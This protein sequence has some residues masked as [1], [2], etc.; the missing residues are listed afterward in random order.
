MHQVLLQG[1][2]R[3][4]EVGVGVVCGI[5]HVGAVLGQVDAHVIHAGPAVAV[6]HRTVETTQG[7]VVLGVDILH[8]SL[9]RQPLGQLGTSC[10]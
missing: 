8:A 10:Q 1:E 2:Q 7:L 4:Q 3:V 9:H 5:L 6:A